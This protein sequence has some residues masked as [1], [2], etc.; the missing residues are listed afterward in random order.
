M[1]D[2]NINVFVVSR[3]S[4]LYPDPH[5]SPLLQRNNTMTFIAVPQLFFLYKCQHLQF[6]RSSVPY[7]NTYTSMF[8]SAVF[9]MWKY[10]QC[11]SRDEWINKV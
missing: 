4:N 1:L 2:K 6:P 7:P 9:S 10:P 11:P 3:T 8:I 5:F